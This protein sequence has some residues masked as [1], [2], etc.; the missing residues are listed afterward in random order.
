[1]SEK[2]SK[3]EKIVFYICIGLWCRLALPG[4]RLNRESGVNPG[5][6]PQLCNP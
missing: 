1:M 4:F 3:K 6:C 2:N 5:L